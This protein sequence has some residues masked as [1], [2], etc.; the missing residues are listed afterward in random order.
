MNISISQDLIATTQK[1]EKTANPAR[2]QQLIAVACLTI[3][4]LIYLIGK[5]VMS[6][7]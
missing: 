2:Q 5:T 7:L 6:V 1:E 3:L 4:P